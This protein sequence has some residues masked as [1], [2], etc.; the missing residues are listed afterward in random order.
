[1]GQRDQPLQ[2]LQLR[3]TLDA[4]LRRLAHAGRHAGLLQPFLQ[5]E[6]VFVLGPLANQT[7]QFIL[8]VYA[9]S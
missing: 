1:M 8:V 4:I 2:M 3:I 9:S 5:G 7:I 6:R